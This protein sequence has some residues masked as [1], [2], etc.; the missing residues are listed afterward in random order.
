MR[1]TIM[2]AL[3]LACGCTQT[4]TDPQ[5]LKAIADLG[6]RQA[7]LEARIA[8]IESIPIVGDS[9]VLWES[10]DNLQNQFSF[11]MPTAEAA[12]ATHQECLDMASRWQFGAAAK[13][14]G[15]DPVVFQDKTWS[16]TL[17]CL[18]KGVDPVPKR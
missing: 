5:T 2:P 17:R 4:E 1:K 13:Q 14:T 15:V 6:Q 10:A 8:K 7:A 11:K 9:W 16:Y 12:Y 18:P 3:L